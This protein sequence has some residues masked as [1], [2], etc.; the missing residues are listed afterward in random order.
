MKK[1]RKRPDPIPAE[2]GRSMVPPPEAYR[3]ENLGPRRT[4]RGQQKRENYQRCLE[5]LAERFTRFRYDKEVDAR[6]AAN[7]ML[8]SLRAA[9]FQ[10][11]RRPTPKAK[12]VVRKK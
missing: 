11:Q 1:G 12:P 5:I 8:S 9:G 7:Y 10:I 3:Q 2:I 6:N 4:T